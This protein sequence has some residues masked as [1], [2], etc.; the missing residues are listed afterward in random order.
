MRAVSK[1]TAEVL[2]KRAL[3]RALLERQMLLRRSTLSPGTL[4]EHL[5]G[6]QAQVPN[7]PYLA[8]WARLE[9]FRHDAL[10][11]LI[12]MR[13]VV[14]LAL[15]RSTIHMVTARDCLELRPLVQPVI[16]RG[17]KG[18]FG[19]SLKGIDSAALAAAARAI[20]EEQPRT[21]NEIG[22]LLNKRWRDRDPFALGYA[23]RA[24][25]P[26]VQVPP[27]GIWG[28]TGPTTRTSVEHWLGRPLARKPSPGR[29]L[30][31]Y[32]GAFG[33]ASVP[34]A[35]SWSGLTGL[36]A[37]IERLG[38][39]LRSF[40]DE[41][42]RELLDLP[43]AP[44]PHAET[45]APPRFL[46]E[47]DNVLL[48]YLD[49]SRILPPEH[50]GKAFGSGALMTGTV[51]IDGFVGARWKLQHDRD[52]ATLAVEALGRVTRQD[53]ARVIEEGTRLL[54]FAAPD[55]SAHDVRFRDAR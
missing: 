25:V 35:Q 18:S 27:R 47:F 29:L 9:D 50:R 39:R 51:L 37:V 48:A 32:F 36:G 52:A 45:E 53:R 28:A 7:A 12:T 33:P 41:H 44:R 42:G 13:R 54:A 31:R 15:M 30:L 43:N 55:G 10:T 3:N 17:L 2:S 5:V 8:L 20:V 22:T 16:E 40:R 49:R 1:R 38:P 11:R 46:P 6:I 23:A 34:D 4:I 21:L 19:R 24:L 26:L 14:R